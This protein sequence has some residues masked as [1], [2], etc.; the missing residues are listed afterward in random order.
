[1]TISVTNDPPPLAPRPFRLRALDATTSFLLLFGGIWA[2]VDAAV[3]IGLSLA[4]G[5][6]WND[7]ILDRRGVAAEGAL[8]SVQR[9]STRVNGHS[10]YRVAYTFTDAAGTARETSSL[11]E[12][13][14]LVTAPP[15]TPLAI[16]Y[17]PELPT[18]TRLRGERASMIGGFILIPVGL[19]LA[20]GLLFALGLR[21]AARTRQIYMHGQPAKAT[22]TAVS[23]TSMRVNGRR[24]MRV[25]Y[26][27]DTIMGKAEGQT[28][29]RDP[30]P[31]GAPIWVI[32][33]G[34]DPKR[35]VE[36]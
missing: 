28:T 4:G 3:V 1:M 16:E 11:T 15:S 19:A 30:P 14:A 24:V 33:D 32:Y 6:Y 13:Y 20:G 35:S 18:R 31:V 7:L 9:T 34:S 5:P 17:D 2:F 22:V 23:G 21:R 29:S 25:A 8:A 12:Q 36:A 10:L 26:V 27:F